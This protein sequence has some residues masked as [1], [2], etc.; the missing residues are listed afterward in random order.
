MVVSTGQNEN[1]RREDR[2]SGRVKESGV[3]ERK[4]PRV[5]ERKHPSVIWNGSASSTCMHGDR[6][7]GNTPNYGLGR[8]L[9]K[10]RSNLVVSS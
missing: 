10:L 9:S 1:D 2:E 4:H 3:K 6:N 7:C 5:K 8:Y